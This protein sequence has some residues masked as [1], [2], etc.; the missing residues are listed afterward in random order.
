[1]AGLKGKTG[2][3][4]G[5]S[6]GIGFQIANVLAQAGATVYV[7]SRTGKPK[8][9]VGESAPGVVHLRG[10]IGNAEA[11]KTLVAEMAAKHNGCLDFLVNNAGVSYKCRA[12]DFPMEQFD[13]IMNVNVKYLFQMSVICYPYLKKS[14]DKGRI[15][16]ITSMSAHLGFSE[17][18]PYCA[19]KGAVL[20]MTR[21]LAVEWAQNNITVNSIAPGWFRSKMNEQV[22]DAAREQKILNRCRCTP[23]VTPATWVRWPSSWWAMVPLTSPDRILP[24]MAAHWRSVIERSFSAIFRQLR[25]YSR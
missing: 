9:G 16:N 13:N 17:V 4:T 19:S 10:D 23:T 5:G 25:S 7:I 1:M 18:V 3:V 11:M 24:W 12:E 20:A 14:A 21:A 6:S 15:I 22:V 2:I 8:E